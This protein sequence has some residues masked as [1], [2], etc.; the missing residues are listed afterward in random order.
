MD[1]NKTFGLLLK[2]GVN[3]KFAKEI[4]NSIVNGDYKKA[5]EILMRSGLDD[6]EIKAF[7]S[8]FF[9]NS[10]VILQDYETE[11]LEKPTF[12]ENKK[13]EDK[14]DRYKENIFSACEDSG[15]ISRDIYSEIKLSDHDGYSEI[16][17]IGDSLIEDSHVEAISTREIKDT[18]VSE[19]KIDL[20]ND[21]KKTIMKGII[22][23]EVLKAKI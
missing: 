11:S 10:K 2:R 7:Y 5:V 20:K 18:L 14:R 3:P 23:S 21:R 6:T 16:S 22:L 12:E 1:F 13:D 19:L 17:D 9:R 15:N 8:D 4:S